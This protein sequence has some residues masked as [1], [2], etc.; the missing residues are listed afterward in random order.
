M[1]LIIACALLGKV[2]AQANAESN[3]Q[4][5]N[6]QHLSSQFTNPKE[7]IVQSWKK[8]TEAITNQQ[9][10]LALSSKN[11]KYKQEIVGD[12]G[13]IYRLLVY[14]NP[15][16]NLELEHWEVDFREILSKRKSKEILSQSLF[17]E[18]ESNPNY[19]FYIVPK[20]H[21]IGVL[22]PEEEAEIYSDKDEPLYG[23]GQGFYYFKTVRK[24][25]IENFCMVIKVG[26]YKF[27]QKK[28]N[29][30]DLFEVFIEFTATCKE[31]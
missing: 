30:L 24:I 8:G 14:H 29:K 3:P 12:S 4:G 13:K 11:K 21:I 23:F 2:N 20:Q 6:S 10:K 31:S 17:Y 15:Y 1:V 27:N 9:V 18:W 22:Y 25:N 16:F 26:D 5:T 7:V 28:K 19:D